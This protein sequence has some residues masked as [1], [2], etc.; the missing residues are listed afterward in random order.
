MVSPP[1]RMRK[2]DPGDKR[3]VHC[4][5]HQAQTEGREV[6]LR[7]RCR[8]FRAASTSAFA[9]G[10]ASSWMPDHSGPIHERATMRPSPM[11]AVASVETVVGSTSKTLNCPICCLLLQLGS[12]PDAGEVAASQRFRAK[13]NGISRDRLSWLH[14][15]D[16]LVNRSVSS[17][18]CRTASLRPALIRTRRVR[19]P[20]LLNALHR[21]VPH[22][23]FPAILH[24]LTRRPTDVRLRGASTSSASRV[25]YSATPRSILL[26]GQRNII[27]CF[28]VVECN[29]C[30]GLGLQRNTRGNLGR[31]QSRPCFGGL[32]LAVAGSMG[33]A[34]GHAGRGLGGS[35]VTRGSAPRLAPAVQQQTVLCGSCA[36]PGAD[37]LPASTMVRGRA[38]SSMYSN[39]Q[40]PF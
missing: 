11:D 2:Q 30:G 5:S 17:R 36:P 26:A 4:R 23:E 33:E 29:L 10:S 27:G 1:L 7:R 31:P 21:E 40:N 39:L 28:K 32:H 12:P 14:R 38:G 18:V 6:E 22:V 16:G 15:L 20:P 19:V 3:G 24:R 25:E 9:S 13:M 8:R 37:S 34:G 35:T